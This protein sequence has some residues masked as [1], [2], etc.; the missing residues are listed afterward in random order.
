MP[1]HLQQ[2][3]VNYCQLLHP[4][5]LV[6]WPEHSASGAV[7]SHTLINDAQN[8]VTANCM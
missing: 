3:L 5:T 1:S 6:R 2:P 4:A 7:F 8:E